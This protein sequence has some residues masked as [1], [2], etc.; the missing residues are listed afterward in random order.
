MEQTTKQKRKE[1]ETKKFQQ[2]DYVEEYKIITHWAPACSGS[3]AEHKMIVACPGA[4]EEVRT[5]SLVTGSKDDRADLAEKFHIQYVENLKKRL[6][7]RKLYGLVNEAGQIFQVR[8]VEKEDQIK[9]D[10]QIRLDKFF[11]K[12]IGITHIAIEE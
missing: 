11:W 1:K 12:P 2:V 8:M 4:E 10:G 3:P 5:V 9:Y 7:G 6:E